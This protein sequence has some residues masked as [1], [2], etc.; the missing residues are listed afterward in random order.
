VQVLQHVHK[1][2]ACKCCDDTI[3][4]AELP[5][6][7]IPKRTASPGL[8]AHITTAKYQ[9]A[10]PLHRQEAIFRRLGIELPRNT[11][12]SWMVRCGELI[13]PL[14]QQLEQQLPAS[15]VIHCDETP[16]Q[17]LQGPDKP[18]T[19][20]WYMWV[21]A[22][23]QRSPSVILCDYTA[24]RSGSVVQTLLP[25]YR[26]YLQTDEYGLCRLPCGRIS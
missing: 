10:L 19:S 11:L 22:S 5:E 8:L 9:D 25:N 12:A 7:A 21:R 14:I 17:V 20:T 1:K 24:S 6:H 23:G 15:S 18:P 13:E 2:Y 16:M 26:G 4:T 3:K